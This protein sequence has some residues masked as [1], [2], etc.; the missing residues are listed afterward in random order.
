MLDPPQ[1]QFPNVLQT[2]RIQEQ[3]RRIRRNQEK[4]KLQPVKKK[5]E[6]PPSNISI[7]VII[8]KLLL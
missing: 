1:S 2:F 4:E 3:L 6:K 5:K 7:K 8:M